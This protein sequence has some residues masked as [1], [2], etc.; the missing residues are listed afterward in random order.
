METTA[1]GIALSKGLRARIED[2]HTQI[3]LVPTGESPFA[4][5]GY[6]GNPVFDDSFKATFR[7]RYEK[8]KSFTYFDVWACRR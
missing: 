2:C 4:M 3:W 1:G 7:R 6:Y 5:T 8:R